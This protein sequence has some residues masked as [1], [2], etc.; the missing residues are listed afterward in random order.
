RDRG[1][2]RHFARLAG[3]LH[4]RLGGTMSSGPLAERARRDRRESSRQLGLFD[5]PAVPG[6][7]R[8]PP[9]LDFTALPA[10]LTLFGI[11]ALPPPTLEI[12]RHLSH[13]LEVHL[14]LLNPSRVYW[15]DIR[16]YREQRREAERN[17]SVDPSLLHRDVGNSLLASL[18]KQSR[19]FIAS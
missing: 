6:S 16:T 8:P 9:A 4:E 17:A 18:G 5:Q 15:F 3:E 13:H 1:R 7:S 11:P 12:V 14:F 2:A 10:R 19:D